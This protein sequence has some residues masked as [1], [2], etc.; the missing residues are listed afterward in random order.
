MHARARVLVVASVLVLAAPIVIDPW[1]FDPYLPLRF[2]VLAGAVMIG[3]LTAG[4]EL[5]RDVPNQVLASWGLLILASMIAAT[6]APIPHEGWL[7][8]SARRSGVLGILVVAG[9]FLVGTATRRHRTW[10]LRAAPVVIGVISTAVLRDLWVAPLAASRT[11]LVGNAG[12]LGGYLVVLMGLSF[13]VLR[14]DPVRAWRAL[15]SVALPLAIAATVLTGSHAAA[16]GLAAVVGL[17]V[18]SRDLGRVHPGVRLGLLI[19]AGGLLAV[20]L[21]WTEQ[22]RALATSWRGR[23]D[24]WSV[25]IDAIL[26]RPWFGWGPEGLRHG[27]AQHVPAEFVARY[28]DDRV[29]DRAHS[30]L[31]DPVAAVGVVGASILA[32]LVVV[33]ARTIDRSTVVDRGLA[34]TLAATLVF[35]LAWFPSL[36]LAVALAWIAGS[37]SRSVALEG[38]GERTADR[39][40]ATRRVQAA[41]G[42]GVILAVAAGT[43]AAV[44]VGGASVVLD[45]QL[46]SS[47]AALNDGSPI[48]AGRANPL[49]VAAH[50]LSGVTAL[51][52]VA[53]MVVR[54]GQADLI[55]PARGEVFDRR[56]AER[57]TIYADL[58]AALATATGERHHLE[59]AAGAYERALLLAPYHSTAWLGLGE[60]RL[61]L[62]EA[63]ADEAL[64]MAA[65]LRPDDVA[66]RLNLAMLASSQDDLATARRWLGEAC[67]IGGDQTQVQQLAASIEG[68]GA[69]ERC[70]RAADERSG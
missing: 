45:R 36:E 12:H 26:A 34:R 28:G 32:V 15:A 67:V 61:R 21:L 10:V 63:S 2:T 7:G 4:R 27:F 13:V 23:V 56:D 41:T 52:V 38:E 29:T 58:S 60:A 44:V 22:F 6:L 17:W 57:M 42:A 40:E 62:G 51:F 19:A 20:A 14:S 48:D 69:K 30:I 37:A 18:A 9:G 50:P 46:G 47:L 24:T 16:A 68:S 53:P 3:V 11:V 59:V 65:R 1:G 8:D 55:E 33:L 39:P 70:R 49:A 5:L 54:S 25:T 31:L 35:L 43:L 66:P 64:A